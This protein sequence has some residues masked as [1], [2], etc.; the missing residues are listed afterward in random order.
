MQVRTIMLPQGV[1]TLCPPGG[2]VLTFVCLR[3][4]VTPILYIFVL[5][6]ACQRPL[7]NPLGTL[8]LV[9]KRK[10]PGS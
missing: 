6:T 9:A 5:L 8:G 3:I 10:I 4:L 1:R 7:E 2:S